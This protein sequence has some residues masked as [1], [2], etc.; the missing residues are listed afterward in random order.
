MLDDIIDDLYELELNNQHFVC[1]IEGL[2]K[3]MMYLMTSQHA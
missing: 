1:T 3:I 2:K